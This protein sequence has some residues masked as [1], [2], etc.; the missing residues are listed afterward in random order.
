[1]KKRGQEMVARY[2]ATADRPLPAE[3]AA[4]SGGGLDPNI[5]AAAALYQ[6]DRIAKARGIPVAAVEKLIGE[7]A[8]AAGGLLASAPLVN[9]LELNLAL[10]K[11]CA[12]WEA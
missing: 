8:F 3:L 11:A 1:V 12:E 6:A 2:G 4:A 5:T 9:V 7:Q 10:D